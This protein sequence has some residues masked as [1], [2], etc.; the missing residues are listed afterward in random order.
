METC[1]FCKHLEKNYADGFMNNPTFS[2]LAAASKLAVLSPQECV[3]KSSHGGI[4]AHDV[5]FVAEFMSPKN[6]PLSVVCR[7]YY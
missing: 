1:I 7:E 6:R 4:D 3:L 2:A 5:A